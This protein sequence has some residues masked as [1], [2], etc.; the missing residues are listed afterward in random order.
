M[1]AMVR[2]TSVSSRS[3]LPNT[4]MAAA[5]PSPTQRCRASASSDTPAYLSS[6]LKARHF[7]ITSPSLSPAT[8]G[9]ATAS[10]FIRRRSAAARS[11]FVMPSASRVKKGS[12]PPDTPA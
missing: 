5:S 3:G 12:L 9:T 2:S 4:A 11:S 7:L 1:P 8:G 10:P 6:G